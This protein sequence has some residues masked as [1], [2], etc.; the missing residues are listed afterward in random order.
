[1]P[2]NNIT[3]YQLLINENNQLINENNNEGYNFLCEKYSSKKKFYY[4]FYSM[5]EAQEYFE[6]DSKEMFIEILNETSNKRN[7]FF[8]KNTCEGVQFLVK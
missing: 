4:L 5:L 2:C 8:M 6:K 7:V 3:S 1:M